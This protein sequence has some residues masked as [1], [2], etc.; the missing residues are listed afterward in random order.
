MLIGKRQNIC[1]RLNLGLK[2]KPRFGF[3]MRFEGKFKIRIREKLGSTHHYNLLMLNNGNASSNSAFPSA[4]D[5][6]T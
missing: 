4:K 3:K 5:L 6:L 2:V 1:L